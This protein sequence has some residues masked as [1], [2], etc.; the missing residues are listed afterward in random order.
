VNILNLIY[1]SAVDFSCYSVVAYTFPN[2]VVLFQDNTAV[3]ADQL[4]PEFVVCFHIGKPL[5][6]RFRNQLENSDFRN[7][8]GTFRH[9]FIL[10]I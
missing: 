5:G 7:R 1:G 10:S 6:F 8:A 4:N 9:I 3:K 2:F